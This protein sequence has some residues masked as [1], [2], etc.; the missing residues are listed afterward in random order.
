MRQSNVG[1]VE[2]VQL[3]ERSVNELDECKVIIGMNEYTIFDNYADLVE[4]LNQE[5][6]YTSRIDVV[7]GLPTRVITDIVLKATVHTVEKIESI[8]LIP[9]SNNRVSINFSQ[10]ALRPGDFIPDATV[11]V[12][13]VEKGSSQRAVWLDVHAIDKEGSTCYVRIFS[14]AQ[15]VESNM[16]FINSL[17][18][19]KVTM[20]IR[21]THYGLQ[22]ELSSVF[23]GGIAE[24][25]PE[26]SIAKEKLINLV[27]QDQALYSYASNT[28]IVGT[29]AKKV[30]WDIGYDLVFMATELYL[31]EAYENISV[32]L[33]V[34]AI[35]RA[36]VCSM[37]YKVAGDS[38][39]SHVLTNIE[40][41]SSVKE[42]KEDEVLCTLLD[43]FS[44]DDSLNS[45]VYKSIKIAATQ[46]F[47]RRFSNV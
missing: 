9:E 22:T 30:S 39:W 32:G 41:A 27:K 1:K 19:H 42:L 38:K 45:L 44:D 14:T 7:R 43:E 5:V 35:K 29:L 2:S 36:I 25:A 18:G 4:M 28:H 24:P 34:Q 37:G 3:I 13:G 46:L 47:E 20:A 16:N 8:R 21:K 10:K 40:L 17:I 12:T 11:I 23:D 31:L 26:V 15:D 6:E 33:D